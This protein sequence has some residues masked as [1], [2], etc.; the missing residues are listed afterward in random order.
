MVL[1]FHKWDALAPIVFN[2]WNVY[3]TQYEYYKAYN[4]IH[5]K[6]S[7]PFMAAL[8]RTIT[9]QC[10]ITLYN[11]SQSPRCH[12]FQ[13]RSTRFDRR[14]NNCIEAN[15]LLYRHCSLKSTALPWQVHSISSRRHLLRRN[16]EISSIWPALSC[17]LIATGSKKG[18]W[19]DK[20]RLRDSTSG[21]T[22]SGLRFAALICVHRWNCG[23]TCSKARSIDL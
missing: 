6:R 8:P 19:T 2:G 7:S 17:G 5:T 23:D 4:F 12:R 16:A 10:M 1:H 13:I 22:T 9:V 20:N 21:Q 18:K 14:I 11:D 15:A 3:T